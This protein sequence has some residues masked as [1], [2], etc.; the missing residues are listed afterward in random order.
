MFEAS[1]SHKHQ[2]PFVKMEMKMKDSQ[3]GWK[4][5]MEI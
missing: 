5:K 3:K 2:G 4:E 1:E